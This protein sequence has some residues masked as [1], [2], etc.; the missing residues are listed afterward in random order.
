[1]HGQQN[2]KL[3]LTSYFN[4]DRT[5]FNWQA[6]IF[7]AIVNNPLDINMANRM[8]IIQKNPKNSKVSNS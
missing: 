6:Q 3:G 4:Y 8:K 2:I 7:V 1:M 5:F